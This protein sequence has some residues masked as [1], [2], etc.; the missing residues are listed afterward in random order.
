M[1]DSVKETKVRKSMY[2]TA[3]KRRIKYK[4]KGL[5]FARPHVKGSK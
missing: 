1:Y 2:Y 5:Y 4:R 3:R